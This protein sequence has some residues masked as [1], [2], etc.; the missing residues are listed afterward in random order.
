MC[1]RD[2]T[3]SVTVTDI[4]GCTASAT[5]AAVVINSATAPTA[6]N[7]SQCGPGIPTCSVTSTVGVGGEFYWYNAATSGT[8][9]QAPPLST[10]Y[11]NTFASSATPATLSGVAAITGGVCRLHT[12]IA[13][14]QGGITVP[15]SGF[16]T[17]QL[18]V[19]FDATTSGTAGNMADGFSYS[20]A[21]NADATLTSYGQEQGTGSKLRISFDAYGS[22]GANMQGIYLL[23]NQTGTSFNPTLGG[24]VLGYSGNT[25]WLN[26]NQHYTITI[27]TSGQ[28]SLSLG[29]TAIFT[30]IQL[31]A[32][33]LTANKA[34]WKH[35][36]AG[37]T[38]GS[39]M[40]TDLDNLV[41]KLALSG[42]TTFL[43]SIS[44]TTTWYVSLSLIHISEPTRPY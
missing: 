1:I 25:S 30:N 24:A 33:Y 36:I 40:Q 12:N 42:S 14:Q 26:S 37:R 7:S 10:Y 11:T 9:V 6:T 19:Q 3:Y 20:F 5:T 29:A 41:I 27:N 39:S 4:F 35:V 15:A 23:Y 38:G 21:P 34:T 8:V 13:S 16:S 22:S 43:S 31:P 17:V 2:R 18:D 28:L 32:D 44:G